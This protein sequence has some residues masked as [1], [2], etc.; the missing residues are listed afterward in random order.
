M[1]F[2]ISEESACGIPISLNMMEVASPF[3]FR[4]LSW[5]PN[6]RSEGGC[7]I[8][9]SFK[10]VQVATTSHLRK[11][12]WHSIRVS[13]E[14]DMPLLF[15]RGW[16]CPFTSLP[17]CV[18]SHSQLSGLSSTKVFC[19]HTSRKNKSLFLFLSLSLSLYIYIYI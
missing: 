4:G 2:H 15:I 5:H 10:K 3:L 14:F 18:T 8:P 7:V 16:G 12:S 11:L 6:L 9:I 1:A 19:H 13:G 17:S